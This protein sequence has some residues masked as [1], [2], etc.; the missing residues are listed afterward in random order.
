MDRPPEARPR[1][2]SGLW[3]AGG[4][5]LLWGAAAA[6]AVLLRDRA[7][8]TPRRGTGAAVCAECHEG[9]ADHWRTSPHARS[10]Q[11]ATSAAGAGDFTTAG[12]EGWPA[13]PW[14][15]EGA[16]GMT[17][18][19]PDGTVEAPI[20]FT[21]GHRWVQEYLSRPAESWQ[22]LPLAFDREAGRWFD[23]TAR[24][25][26]EPPAPG[27]PWHWTGRA[28]RWETACAACHTGRPF[29]PEEA[30]AVPAP[31]SGVRSIGGGCG[32]CVRTAPV[33]ARSPCINL[34]R[35]TSSSAADG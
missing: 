6:G 26:G 33:A 16:L 29:P 9:V 30:S 28:R 18:A 32:V 13:R 5:L 17:I 34:F 10:V 24:E 4:V 19:G 1:R 21:V 20:G 35:S 15:R 22:V 14:R 27:S 8:A 7:L 12:E 31:A 23:R 11:P 25:W 3:F 2:R